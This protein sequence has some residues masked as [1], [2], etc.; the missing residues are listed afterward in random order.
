M[1]TTR[2]HVQIY[3]N[4]ST[5]QAR[6]NLIAQLVEGQAKVIYGN[7][8]REISEDT[9]YDQAARLSDAKYATHQA[10][11]RY[12]K[13]KGEDAMDIIRN[14]VFG[15]GTMGNF[16]Y[17]IQKRY[18]HAYKFQTGLKMKIKDY[19][20]RLK[21]INNFLPYFPP[22]K[23]ISS[24]RIAP[25]VIDNNN[26]KD[27]LDGALPSA[28]KAI[29]KRN[30]F[31][32]FAHPINDAMDYLQDVEGTCTTSA[33]TANSNTSNNSS[34]KG[35]NSGKGKGK[36]KGKSQG[37]GNSK[38]GSCPHCDKYHFTKAGDFSD[39]KS[40]VSGEKHK[41]NSS[42]GNASNKKSRQKESSFGLKEL[43]A[44]MEG[45]KSKSL[46]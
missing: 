41:F 23:S 14:Y 42:K 35:N 11:D 31:N 25:S 1:N 45:A 19:W 34:N 37:L 40:L 33:R 24:L 17:T 3:K 39:C 29:C 26:L 5:D 21:E 9:Q 36:G 28:F 15:S 8:T 12:R 22:D 16:I 4:F 18:L 27:T 13:E 30:Q 44:L 43:A 6:D 2:V 46:R 38:V 10:S 7:R 32:V 20:R